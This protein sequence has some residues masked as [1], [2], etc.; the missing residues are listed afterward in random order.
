MKTLLFAAVALVSVTLGLAA[1]GEAAEAPDAE[2]EA[3]I[4]G[5]T[6]TNGRMVLAPVEGNPAAVYFDLAYDGDR[7]FAV[8][9]ADV[10]GAESAMLHEYGEYDFKV[11]MMEA[12]P[13]VLNKG[14]EVAFEP[15]GRHVMAMNPSPDLKPGGTTEVT[16]TVSGGDT[17]SF[18]VEIRAAGEER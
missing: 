4:P 15:G 11:Q 3:G 10:E 18:P 5:M 2:E 16:L 12:L 17:H 14:D 7:S 1:C 13:I 6:V 9:R 8:R